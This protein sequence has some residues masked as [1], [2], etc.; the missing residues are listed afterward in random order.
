MKAVHGNSEKKRTLFYI[1]IIHTQADM[2]A[3]KDQIKTAS[4]RKLGLTGWKR[5]MTLIEQYWTE[6]EKKVDQLNLQLDRVKIYQDALPVSGKEIEI[7]EELASA[8][9]RNHQLL[10]RLRKDGAEIM[11]TES[12]EYL[13]EE[14]HAAKSMLG[15][16]AQNTHGDEEMG[17]DS[18]LDK[19]DK[20]IAARINETLRPGNIGILFIGAL[21][22]VEPLL[23]R[24]IEIIRPLQKFI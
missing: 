20:F 8:G 21:H 2:G 18:I 5:K 22:R 6:I 24:D 1:P 23:D 19:R 9:S 17:S 11:G 16:K 12:L 13:L 7:V 15:S 14:Y 4:L 3:L 10:L